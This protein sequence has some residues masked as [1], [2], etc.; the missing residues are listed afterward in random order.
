MGRAGDPRSP[1]SPPRSGPGSGDPRGRR[2]ADRRRTRPAPPPPQLWARVQAGEVRASYAR[3]VVA[4]DPRPATR[5]SSPVDAG[6]V[7]SGRRTDPWTVRD[8]RRGQGRPSR[9]D[10]ARGRRTAP[11]SATFARKLRT[12]A[13]GMGSFLVRGDIAKINALRP[14]S[15]P[16]PLQPRRPVPRPDRRRTPRARGVPPGLRPRP[17]RPHRH[18]NRPS[19]PPQTSCR[20]QTRWSTWCSAHC[21]PT[22]APTAGTSPGSRATGPVTETWLR[23]VLGPA[24]GSPSNSTLAGQH[25]S[26]PAGS[27]TATA[28][29]ST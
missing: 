20:H 6:V 12:D 18:P 14:R 24:P 17:R 8:A 15:P 11:A 2:A 29:R 10:L 21:T 27:P 22:P 19:R 25:P 1:S 13:H 23:D 16:T 26:T 9:P 3:H 28:P 4:R 5:R 7:E